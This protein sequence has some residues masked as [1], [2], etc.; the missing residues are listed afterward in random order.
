[1][2]NAFFRFQNTGFIL[3]ASLA[4]AA[5]VEVTNLHQRVALKTIIFLGTSNPRYEIT[6]SNSFS[7]SGNLVG[8]IVHET[9]Y[10]FLNFPKFQK[11]DVQP[12]SI[13]LRTAKHCTYICVPIKQRHNGNRNVLFYFI[14]GSSLSSRLRTRWK[15]IW[16]TRVV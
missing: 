5:A 6:R 15:I 13:A 9:A 12:L 14:F 8:D 3:F 2:W 1:M 10:S 7:C 4:M 11:N 16:A